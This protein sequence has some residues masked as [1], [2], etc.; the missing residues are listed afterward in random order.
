MLMLGN[1][2]R[3]SSKH[4][5]MILKQKLQSPMHTVCLR[6]LTSFVTSYVLGGSLRRRLGGSLTISCSLILADLSAIPL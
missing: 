5:D 1:L 3:A 6:V 4:L 2:E